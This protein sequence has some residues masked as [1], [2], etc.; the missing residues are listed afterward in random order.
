MGAAVTD[1]TARLDSKHRLT[2][3]GAKFSY[4]QVREYENGCILL[5]PRELTVP[6]DISQKALAMMDQAMRNYK[7]GDVSEPIDLSEF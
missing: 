6:K 5:E 7:A 4:Y 2:L 1:Y 3:R